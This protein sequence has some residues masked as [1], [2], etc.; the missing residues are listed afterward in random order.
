MYIEIYYFKHEVSTMSKQPFEADTGRV[1]N[2]VINSLYSDKE[3]FL[4]ELIS[5]SSDAIDKRRFQRLSNKS[6]SKEKLDYEIK[7]EV[8]SKDNVLC[9][10]DNGIGM[11]DED[12]I[13][14]L[15]TI[16]KSGTT[17]FLS[18][19]ESA[20]KDDKSESLNLIGQFGVGFYA[21][22]MVSEKVE[23]ISKKDGSDKAF[24]WTS[25]G[26]SGFEIKDS[27]RE[28]IGTTVKLSL[29]KSEKDYTKRDKL[30]EIIKK[31][32]DHIQFP[33]RFVG[34]KSDEKD[35]LNDASAIWMKPKSEITKE[36]YNEF[37]SQS[38]GGFGQPLITMHNKAEGM[39]SY[40]SLLFIP[41]MKPFDLFH[42][43]R[44]PKVKLYANRV[45]ITDTLDNVLPR[46]LRFINGVLDTSDL[47]LNVSR[48]MLQHSPA[49]RRISKALKK[50]IINELKKLKD[51]DTDNYKKFW[52]EFGAVLKEGIYEDTDHKM[53]ILN[54]SKF[55][56]SNNADEIYLSE[57][58]E[59]MHKKQENIFYIA[60]D[61]IEQAINSPHL[62]AFK[63]KK[64]NVLFLIDPIDTFW[65]SNQDNFEGKKF[66]SITQ[67][68]LDLSK[69]DE[70]KDDANKE[71]NVI[72]YKDLIEGIKK[73]LGESI[74][75]VRVSD[76]LID[77]ACCLV[78]SDSG[79]D[80]QMEKIMKM[81]NKDFKGMP[82]ILEVNPNHSLMN[83][84]SK[85]LKSNPKE[86]DDLSK[87]VLDQARLLEGH[88]PSDVSFYCKK[89]NELI[90]VNS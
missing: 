77:S 88:L 45:F 30:V 61:T 87:I 73:S 15:G 42:V 78:A 64:I 1:L 49:L 79:M 86:F 60:V 41:E 16:A 48:E 4:R 33:I 80:V 65:L 57:Y 67:G 84:M 44:S 19:L 51:K 17:E 58:V 24:S 70:K 43:D 8:S 3:I 56:S 13:N 89:I 39:I 29:K 68:S 31:Y 83:Y 21:A 50:K 72:K 14:S 5:N 22:F 38:G 55:K 12:L 63:S 28:D 11:D 76:K 25:D 85:V 81:Q 27:N 40:T 66:V 23:V 54:L 53:D 74:S 6:A 7:I 75:D 36:Q 37:F 35:T 82:R 18:Q 34:G 47:N 62:E 52:S 9:I 46:W 90:T 20:K 2:I 32:S 10:S 71:S 26:I 59:S 69:F